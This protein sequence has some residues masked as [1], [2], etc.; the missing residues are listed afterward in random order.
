MDS[1]SNNKLITRQFFR[2][3]PIQILLAVIPSL[4]GI[5]SS[6]FAGNFADRADDPHLKRGLLRRRWRPE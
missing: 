5:I 4:N 6:I 1:L 2:L 3:L